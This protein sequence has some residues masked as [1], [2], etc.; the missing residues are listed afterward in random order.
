MLDRAT[1]WFLQARGGRLDVVGEIGRFAAT[2]DALAPRIP[3][4]LRGAER[5]RFE[6]HVESLT[7]LGAPL[8]LARR[9]AALLDEFSLLDIVDLAIEIGRAHV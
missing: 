4:M 8:P 2:V 5:E 1:R 7:S 6:S 9:V 3:G